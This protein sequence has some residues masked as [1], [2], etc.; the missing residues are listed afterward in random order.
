MKIVDHLTDEMLPDLYKSRSYSRLGNQA[1][2]DVGADQG[3]VSVGRLAA[4]DDGGGLA[5]LAATYAPP[6]PALSGEVGFDSGRL[7]E[8]TIH[9]GNWAL[10]AAFELVSPANKDRPDARRVFMAKV[11]SYLDAGASVVVVDAITERAADLHGELCRL[12]D[13]PPA[14][15]WTS[16]SGLSAV[17]Y[18]AVQGSWSVKFA[19]PDG[20]LRLEV[21]PHELR[22]G[23]PLPT[24]PLW[25]AADLAV[26]F[27]LGATYAAACRSLR[28][29]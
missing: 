9:R 25:L 15:A 27:E 23:D 24:V 3:Q 11:A 28:L 22:V 20:K 13:L 17:C 8:V 10:V 12:L 4:P 7:F 29:A 16:P 21:W 2:A 18:R 5:T 14:F 1:E 19:I 6:V 26:P